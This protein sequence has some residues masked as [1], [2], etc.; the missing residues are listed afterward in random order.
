VIVRPGGYGG[1]W[2][3]G[4]DIDAWIRSLLAS[5]R[6]INKLRKLGRA[7]A[8]ERHLVIVLDSFS[9]AGMGISMGL[10]GRHERGAVRYELPSFR[11]PEPLSHLW[12]MPTEDAWEGLSWARAVGWTILDACW[13]EP[14]GRPAQPLTGSET[15]GDGVVTT[16][17]L[18][19]QPTGAEP[20]IASHAISG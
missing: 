9:Q 7:T 1:F 12:I 13:P 11:A 2:W 10:L 4:R 5:D 14:V 19:R 17:R 16:V 15:D 6:G 8:V 3:R 20:D 18:Q